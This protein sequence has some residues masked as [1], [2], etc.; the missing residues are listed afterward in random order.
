MDQKY[1]DLRAKLPRNLG[2]FYGGEFHEPQTAEFITVTSPIDG[3]EITKVPS[4]GASDTVA[5]LEAAQTAFESWRDVS[6]VDRCN[7]IRKAAQILRDHKE[8]LAVLDAWNIG[9]PVTIMRLEVE[10]AAMNLDMLAGLPFAVTGDTHNLTSDM[11]HYTL[12]EPLGVVARIVAYNHP[13]LMVAVKLLFPVAVGNTVVLKAAEQAPLSALRFIELL[14]PVFPKGVIN[15]LTGGKSCGETLSSHPIV[16]RVTL[17]GS[18]PIGRMISKAAADTLKLTTFEL[19]GKNALVAYPDAD[20]PAL[21]DGIVKGMNWSWCGQSCS[22]TSRVFLHESLHDRVLEAVVDKITSDYQPGDPLD[23]NTTMGALVDQK[24]MA[25][26][27]KYIAMGKEDGAR[28]VLGGEPTTPISGGSFMM[29]TV[30]ADVEQ[31]MRIAREEIFG[32]VMCVLKWTDE[33]KM[34]EDVNSV[35]YGLTGA[36]YSSNVATAHKA[37]K[38]MEAGYIWVNTSSTHF[39]GI[40]FGGYKQSG[41]GRE[42]DLQELYDMTQLKAV[43]VCL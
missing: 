35:E 21:V 27:Q 40:P 24:A 6:T 16:Q 39:L 13:I 7:L 9:S 43:H 37:A 3:Q 42:H 22:S 5:A 8:E 31:S 41:K 32:P 15:V 2:L 18:V 25:R 28:L 30:F 33:A 38:K 20:V 11:F 36:I 10:Y 29:P 14:A 23:D 12:R 34:W 19:G 26:V 4:A 1:P 17:V